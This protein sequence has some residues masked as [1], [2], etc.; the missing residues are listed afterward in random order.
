LNVAVGADETDEFLRQSRGY[1][2]SCLSAGVDADL[3]TL[4]ACNHYTILNQLGDG[5]TPLGRAVL[6]QMG[7]I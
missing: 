6:R 1:A 5:E 7:L 4:E 3:L 2:E